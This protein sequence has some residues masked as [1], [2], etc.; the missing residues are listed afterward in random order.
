MPICNALSALTSAI[1][2]SDHHLRAALV[3]H[4]DAQRATGRYWGS[5]AVMIKALVAVSA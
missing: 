3:E 5:G 1:K 2:L 4:V